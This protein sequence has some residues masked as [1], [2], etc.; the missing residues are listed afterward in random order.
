MAAKKK[1]VQN[2][3]SKVSPKENEFEH[4]G[5]Q[6]LEATVGAYLKNTLGKNKSILHARKN[7]LKLIKEGQKKAKQEVR[8]VE[9]LIKKHPA[10]AVLIASAV[11]AGI[12]AIAGASV[13]KKISTG[14]KK[15]SK[16]K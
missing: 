2:K 10:A 8:D 16:K 9:N 1:T 15:T 3:V 12:G 5:L 4:P 14:K 7:A 11:G 6:E 13:E